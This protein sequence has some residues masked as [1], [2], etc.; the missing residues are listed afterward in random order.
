MSFFDRSVVCAAA[1]AAVAFAFIPAPANAFRLTPIV[2]DFAPVGRDAVKNFRVTNTT[3]DSI[4]VEVRMARRA[5]ETDGEE[6]LTPEEEDFTVYPGQIVVEPG[7]TQ[8]IQVRWLGDPEP[9]T[10][11][12]YRIIAE[13]L[14]VELDAAQQDVASVRL[15]VKYEGS[16]YIVPKGA[17]ADIALTG[18]ARIDGDDGSDRLQVRLANRGDAHGIVRNP[19]LTLTDS[20]GTS[21]TLSGEQADALNNINILAGGT[22]H[23]SLPWPNGLQ[24]GNIE[25]QLESEIGR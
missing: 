18:V 21:V 1:L 20:Q 9:T 17:E 6:V 4:A 11:L 16:V 13:Q 10:E 14:P 2:Q 8:T 25:G 5:I 22:R 24:P 12:A 19:S 23:V 7:K 15:L 3:P